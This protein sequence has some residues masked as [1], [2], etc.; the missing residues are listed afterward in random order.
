MKS[1]HLVLSILILLTASLLSACAGG[2]GLANSWPGLSADEDNAYLAFNNH[3]YAIAL[4]SGAEK[5]RFPSETN[6]RITLYAAPALS[7]DRQLVVGGYNNILYSLNPDTGQ[8]LWEFD[9]AGNKYLASPL[10]VEQGIFAPNA[11]NYLYALE[12]NGSLRWKFNTQGEIW[13]QPVTD[14]GCECIYL[15]SMDHRVYALNPTNGDLRWQSE[16]LGGAIVGSPALSEEG[17]LYIGTFGREI[18]ALDAED[19]S[20]I[21]RSPTLGWVWGGPTLDGERLYVGDLD[22]NFYALNTADGQALWSLTPEQLDG[23]IVGSPLIIDE[24]IYFSSE[25]GSLYA[26]D[27]TG[28]IL[29]SQAI[30]GRLLAAPVP[31]GDLLLVT[32]NQ[33]EELLVAV[34]RDG[35]AR[36]WVFTPEN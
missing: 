3:V 8:I 34:T 22:G 33:A 20:V 16:E 19:G 30:G 29:W 15:T 5:W 18:V 12:L 31:A 9:Q 1:N 32:P 28:N 11:D 23:S 24:S 4:E 13:A 7:L 27:A 35:G 17:V 2:A 25:S 14:P 10:A 21:W 36:R 26:L 6:N